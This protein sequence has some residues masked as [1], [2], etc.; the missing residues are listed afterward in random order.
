M[1]APKQVNQVSK[2]AECNQISLL[3]FRKTFLK[4]FSGNHV[5]LIISILLILSWSQYQ[6]WNYSLDFPAT[7]TKFKAIFSS[8]LWIF[9]LHHFLIK[10]KP[11]CTKLWNWFIRG[12]Y[13]YKNFLEF[14]KQDEHHWTSD[15]YISVI[16]PLQSPW[17]Y[18]DSLPLWKLSE[19]K[20]DCSYKHFLN[21]N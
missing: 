3:K 15:K 11:N 8:F 1:D 9:E 6:V 16:L 2:I 20:Y 18:F 14:I 10:F 7:Y 12:S 21:P 17:R 19:W 13:H 5:I 4:S